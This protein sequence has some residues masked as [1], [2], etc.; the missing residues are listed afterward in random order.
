M[1][2]KIHMERAID[3]LKRRILE[4]GAEVE[5]A[6][7]RAFRALR[8]WDLAEARRVVEMDRTIDRQELE[9]EEDCLK[10]L[11]LYQPVAADLR[12]VISIMK[13]NNDLERIGDL[14]KNI[15]DYTLAI[16]RCGKIEIPGQFDEMFDRAMQMVRDS[17]DAFVNFDPE[18]A[19]EVCY[20]DDDVDAMNVRIIGA[21][22]ERLQESP[23]AV[24]QLLYLISVSRGVERMADYA[25]NIAEDAFYMITGETLR[26]RHL[27]R[28][29]TQEV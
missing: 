13:I 14:A 26:H 10:I 12:R 22:R 6:T 24:D 28:Q 9:I 20:A 7:G 25:T 2:H 19:R 27:H 23:A 29:P 3:R 4:M 5:Q 21:I 17:L 18:L 1:A 16:A 8:R 15:A 11:A